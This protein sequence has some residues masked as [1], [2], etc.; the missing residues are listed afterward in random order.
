MQELAIFI[1]FGGLVIA[2]AIYKTQQLI[3]S[4][5]TRNYQRSW[6]I[7]KYFMIVFFFGYMTI[8]IFVF[9]GYSRIIQSFTG[10][11][12][13]LVALLVYITVKIGYSTLKDLYSTTVSKEYLEKVVDSMTDTLIVLKVGPDLRVNL[14]NQAA[15]NL[16]GYTRDEIMNQPV[17]MIFRS[18]KK[19]EYYL[20]NCKTDSCIINEE[21]NYF[22]KNGEKIQMLLSIACI[23]N[24]NN[25]IEE[26]IIAAQNITQGLKAEKALLASELRYRKLNEELK[27]SNILKELLLDVIVHDLK[28]PLGLIQGFAS[29]EKEKDPGNDNIQEICNGSD[30]LLKA[31]ENAT[32][33]S[34]VVVGDKIDKQVIN[35]TEMIKN[36]TDDFAG[37][38]KS[39]NMKLDFNLK[40]QI[41]I[42]ANPIISDVFQNYISNAIKYGSSG[43]KLIINADENDGIVKFNFVDF[44]ET[45]PKKERNNIFKR[46]IQL[47]KTIGSGMGLAIVKCIAKAHNAEVGIEPNLPKGNVFYIKI[48]K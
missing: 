10:A 9:L 11:I 12:F 39:S 22:A 32:V 40:N 23:K 26:L 47:N 28:N 41:K 31:L 35:F 36:L 21:T 44:G 42:K 19:L 18:D 6:E 46:N 7:L 24:F 20:D 1:S 14:V 2:F 4:H 29:F 13:F 33:I 3:N 34:K 17:N 43:G 30:K 48:P 8:L 15:L 45:I 16:L 27:E 38:L 37:E 5:F 25:E